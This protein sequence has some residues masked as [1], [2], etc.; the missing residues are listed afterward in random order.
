MRN[1]LVDPT[2]KAL[3]LARVSTKEQVDNYS[4]QSQLTDLA[5]LARQDGF[6]DVEV[7]KEAGFSGESLEKRPV[8]Q[9]VLDEIRLGN[10]A[11]LYIANWSR[12]SRDED[13]QDGLTIRQVCREHGVLIRTPERWYD[14]DREDDDVLADI[15]FIFAKTEK[16]S[17]NKR[18]AQGQYTKAASGGFAGG[19]TR[20][21]YRFKYVEEETKRGP[22][23][24]CDLEKDGQEIAIVRL[25]HGNFPRFS[26]R[27]IAR[28][29]NRLAKWGRVMYFPIKARKDRERAGKDHREWHQED[30]MNI[31]RNRWLIGQMSYCAYDSPVYRSGKRKRSRHLRGMRTAVTY[32]EDLRV[33]DD[34]L[35]ERNNRIL[36]ER[37]KTASRTV[38]SRHAF[39]SLLKCPDCGAS[40]AHHGANSDSYFCRSAQTSGTCRGFSVHESAARNV[41]VPLTADILQLNL[42]AAIIKAKK[43]QSTDKVVAEL[44]AEIKRI[45]A[46]AE[47]LIAYA[48]Q[49]A[50]TVEQLR[51]QNM[52]LLAEK[53]TKQARLERILNT[54]TD[55]VRLAAFTDE[56]L[57]DL[58]GFMEYLYAHRTLFFNQIA[59]LVFS[60]VVLNTDRRG[61]H[62][63][64]GLVL[65]DKKGTR[66]YHLQSVMFD[67]R[68]QEW[69]EQHGFVMPQAIR[70]LDYGCKMTGVPISAQS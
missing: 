48:R 67:P 14:L 6:I 47:N 50:I 3:V 63:K 39:S 1:Q 8:L 11:A 7:H 58:P 23:L 45:D 36:D 34:E 68:F 24:K 61:A 38:S 65:G 13:L 66:A 30:I 21:G 15:Q 37:G 51:E 9:R 17:I 4:W 46:E 27:R 56:F 59:R 10:V 60:G 18:M 55:Q 33:L 5:T 35:F 22:R 40:L 26:T 53:Q 57:A 44:R 52:R 32:R 16:R 12:A 25:I 2:R 19:R 54:D 69:T 70:D 49:G 62:W 31:I 29:L 41:L 64:K 42:R 28:I 20:F 43:E